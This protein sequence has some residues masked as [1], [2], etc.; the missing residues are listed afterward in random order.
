MA[1]ASLPLKY[2]FRRRGLAPRA[3]RVQHV[4]LLLRDG[5]R[6]RAVIGWED[7]A[8]PRHADA[9][10]PFATVEVELMLRRPL[11]HAV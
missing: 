5:H 1:G 10:R 7:H 11:L 8:A 2:R 3:V 4:L 6:H 9:V